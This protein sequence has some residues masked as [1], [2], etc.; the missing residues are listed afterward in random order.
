MPLL[1]KTNYPD[2]EIIVLDNGSADE[3]V[4]YLNGEKFETVRVIELSENKGFAEGTNTAANEANGEILVLLNNDIEVTSNW[5]FEAVK[6][7]LTDPDAAAVQSKIMQYRNRDKIDC[8]GISVDKYGILQGIGNGEDDIGQYDDLAE[9]GAASGGAMVVWKR[10]FYEVGCFDP[11]FFMYYEDIDLSWRIR[12]AGYKIMPAMSSVVYHVGSATSAIAPTSFVPF[13]W[14]KN[15]VLCWLKNSSAK[16]VAIFWP[17]IIFVIV[18]WIIFAILVRQPRAALGY[19]KG[20]SWAFTHIGY[21]LK[22][23]K[24]F[25]NLIKKSPRFDNRLFMTEMNT[26]STN[27]SY[28]MS[29]ARKRLINRGRT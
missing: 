29:R 21:V 11:R 4:Q 18:S 10:I 7:L 19:L 25:K 3:S 16:T 17:V 8:I 9:I 27:L 1:T 26:G 15:Y 22:A 6:K 20:A 24:I 28:L 14:A 12:S 13:Q 23:R 5:L 2:F